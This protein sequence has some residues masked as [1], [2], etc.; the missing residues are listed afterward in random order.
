MTLVETSE[1]V[2]EPVAQTLRIISFAM[3]AGLTA[4]AGLVAWTYFN[5][6]GEA[7]TPDRVRLINI[8]TTVAMAVT[9]SAIA[10]SE[11]LWRRMLKKRTGALSGAVQTAFIVRLALREGP[12]LLGLTA[13]YLAAANGTLKAYPAYWVNAVPYALFLTFLAAHWPTAERLASEAREI[14]L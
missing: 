8:L 4:M 12:G 14:G 2:P 7:P 9:L 3:A 13:A 10:A 5:Y 1:G 6:K 11:V